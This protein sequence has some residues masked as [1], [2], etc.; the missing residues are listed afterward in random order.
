MKVSNKE[1]RTLK[2]ICVKL[3]CLV[4]LFHLYRDQSTD[5]KSTWQG[6]DNVQS[7]LFLEGISVSIKVT[8]NNLKLLFLTEVNIKWRTTGSE[9]FSGS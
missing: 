7:E 2:G 9:T 8:E 3:I 6:S 1:N 5:L 4:V